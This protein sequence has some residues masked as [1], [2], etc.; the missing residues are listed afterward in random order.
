M[1][2]LTNK[3]LGNREKLNRMAIDL[4][5]EG[6]EISN[7]LVDMFSPATNLLGALGDKVRIYRQLS[8][9]RSIKRANEIAAVEG[10]VLEEPPLKFLVPFMEECSLESPEDNDMIEMWARLLASSSSEYKSEHHLFIRI[11]KEITPGEAK[12][13]EYICLP[14]TS[15]KNQHLEDVS[16]SWCDVYVYIKL[17]KIID[18]L[19]GPLG[20]N[21]DFELVMDQFYGEAQERGT[22]V[23]FFGVT[24]GEKGIYPVDEVYSSPRGAIDDDYERSSIAILKSL[25]I[26]ADYSSPEFWFGNYCFDIR[27][28]HLTE[29][30]AHFINACTAI[31]IRGYSNA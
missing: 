12:L 16:S 4:K 21:T 29:L 8:L 7:A 10:L 24:E 19:T 13:L 27:A 15:K 6:K 1:S 2:M 5:L 9:M 22:V 25:G 3:L 30:G 26:L 23:Y 14:K 28:Y 11:L 18:S 20:G 31:D 17:Q